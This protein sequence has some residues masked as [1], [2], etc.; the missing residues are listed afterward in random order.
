MQNNDLIGEIE[1]FAPLYYQEDYDNSGWQLRNGDQAAKG[2]L[3]CLDVTEEV[4]Q[5]AIEKGCNLIIAHHPLIFGHLKRLTN[6]N[7]VQRIISK[8]I[9]ND[10]DIYAA[11]TNMDSMPNGVNALIA[12]KLGVQNPKILQPKTNG[13]YELKYYVPTGQAVQV[14][15]ALFAAGAGTLGHYSECAF[16]VAGQGSFRANARANPTIGVAGGAR[17]MVGEQQVAMVVQGHLRH[18][19]LAALLHAHPYEEVA[20][21]LSLLQN[22]NGYVGAGMQGM[23]SAAIDF[24]DFLQL[25]KSAMATACIKYTPA[26]RQQVQ[27]IAICG[28]SGSF[29]L[30]EAIAQGCDV[31]L[32]ADFKYHQYFEAEGRIA[33]V[34]IG[35]YESEQYTPE[36]FY[37]ILKKK[38]SNFAAYI[39]TH[40]TN[41]I[42]YL[43]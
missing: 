33:I 12:K 5:E 19:V 1:R 43:A 36:I 22:D 16:A 25:A 4:L 28:G 31:L 15:D 14:A 40:N 13:L 42:K 26:P 6:A 34:D 29:L 41:P 2:A 39:T 38:F 3:L 35:H 10:I 27:K 24:Q 8:A 9:K 23:L 20:Y 30:Q 11:H 7:M 21:S 37:H 17:E 32:T 18:R